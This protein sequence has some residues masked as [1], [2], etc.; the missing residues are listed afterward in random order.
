MFLV[1]AAYL[2]FAVFEQFDTGVFLIGLGLSVVGGAG[3]SRLHP[4]EATVKASG[5][6]LRRL[7]VYGVIA[8]IVIAIWRLT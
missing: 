8:I 7:P 5:A 3:L 2:A 6:Q 4:D 1:G